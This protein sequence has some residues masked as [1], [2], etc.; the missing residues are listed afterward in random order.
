MVP[1]IGAR[2]PPAIADDK[3]KKRDKIL[4]MVGKL[5]DRDTQA[6]AAR[7]LRDNIQVG[8]CALFVSCSRTCGGPYGG[9]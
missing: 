3:L 2:T 6:I 7:E 4:L 8:D 9:N 5:N 1:S